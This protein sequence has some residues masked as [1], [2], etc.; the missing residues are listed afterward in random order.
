MTTIKLTILEDHVI[1]IIRGLE[2]M[3]AVVI[4][5]ENSVVEH[6]QTT[7]TGWYGAIKNPS[8]D[9]VGYADK[10]RGEWDERI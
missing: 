4:E 10:V 8:Q 2:K 5:Q 9:L 6:P 7:K 3:K 1:D